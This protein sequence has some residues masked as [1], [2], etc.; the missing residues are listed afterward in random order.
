MKKELVEEVMHCL[1]DERKVFYF[2]K[3]RYC[4]D[5]LLHEMHRQKTAALNIQQIKQSKH[6][7]LLHKPILQDIKA[8]AG[9]GFIHKEQLQCCAANKTLFPFVLGLSSWGTG[10]R[11]GDQTTRNQA[12]LVLQL[13]FSNQHDAVY[14]SLVKPRKD[15]DNEGPFEYSGHPIAG[16]KRN[17][18]AWVRMDIDFDTNEVLIEE[19][20]M[21]WL[22]YVDRSLRRIKMRRRRHE[23][24]KP[25]DAW[26]GINGSYENLETYI[27]DVV[28]PYRA[29][30]A[31][32]ALTA[33][34]DFIRSELGISTIYYHSLDTGKKMKAV[35]GSPP[36]SIYTDLPKKFGFVKTNV[37]PEMVM[38]DKFARRCLKKVK[39]PQWQVL[40]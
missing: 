24:A 31:E 30:W 39:N 19:V 10:R 38:N 36:R 28:T 34:I 7:R 9:D 26:F 27:D 18:L 32:A 1:G 14:Q 13:N 21:D 33:A 2:Y 12:N 8:H 35:P 4:I 20:Q 37:A 17:T 3:N 15:G 16:G 6:E 29:I 23:K 5:H 25:S 22:R 11:G 40:A